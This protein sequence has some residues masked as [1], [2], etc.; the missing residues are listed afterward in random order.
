MTD[1]NSPRVAKVRILDLPYAADREYDYSIP[2]A[3]AGCLK[4]GSIASVSFGA[5]RRS[6]VLSY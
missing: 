1:K 4:P 2:D 5:S 3:L 6:A